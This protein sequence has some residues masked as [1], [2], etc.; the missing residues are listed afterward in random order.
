[1]K[2]P[3]AAVALGLC[4]L[5]AACGPA[6]AAVFSPPPRG[7]LTIGTSLQLDTLN[8]VTMS[9]SAED[10]AAHFVWA[11]LLGVNASGNLFPL[12]ASKVPSQKNGMISG[13]GR[14]VTFTLRS[15]LRWSDGRSLTAADVRFGWEVASKPW[16][17]LCP[18]TCWAIRNVVVDSPRQ[19]TFLLR[20]PFS[21]LL[22]DLPPVLPRHQMWHGSWRRTFLYI[23]QPTTDFLTPPL[24]V[25]GPYQVQLATPNQ[26][27]LVRNRYWN[28]LKRPAYKRVVIESF[29]SDQDMIQAAQTGAVQISQG[30]YQLDFNRQILS[31]K[32]LVG[33]HLHIYPINGV[34]LLEPNILGRWQQDPAH[35]KRY[36]YTDAVGNPLVRQALNLAINRSQLLEESISL[37][38]GQARKLVTYSPEIRQR[39]D[40]LAV[41]GVWDPLKHRYVSR[42]QLADARRLLQG[43]GW[44]LYSDGFRYRAGCKLKAP[45][46][47]L[48]IVFVAPHGDF[49]R[50]EE[51]LGLQEMWKKIGV[52]VILD[53]QHWGVGNI[54][55]GYGE[56]G[57]CAR[58]W[59]DFCLL[60]QQPG[61]DPQTDFQLQ[62]TSNHIARIKKH[63]QPADINFAGTRNPVFDKLFAEAP[64]IYDLSQ[65]TAL[66]RKWQVLTAQNANW[67][68]LFQRPFIVV[69]RGLIR[70]LHPSPYG[71][72]WN[73]WA[74]SPG[75][76]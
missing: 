28:I 72:E 11:G 67:I 66:Y 39:F 50:Y 31:P 9:N 44:R 14:S 34:E 48:E 16:A 58:G 76:G 5:A 60:S 1:M 45:G 57:P 4:L 40:G 70:H 25:D 10:N 43:A 7:E 19:V 35:P 53:Y 17:V 21:P 26:V 64:R 69:T 54:T 32:T 20:R 27:T 47:Q 61:Y 8:P 18:A 63:P 71:V 22:F 33:L 68:P 36:V 37:T 52:N 24:A 12:L 51:A 2:S 41:P 23:Y 59:D 3:S 6:A 75:S 38:R 56:R 74:L 15:H 55:A 13:S 62:F 30:Y 65:R 49:A 73:P 46:C 29:K 42:P